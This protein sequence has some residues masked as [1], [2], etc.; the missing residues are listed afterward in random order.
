MSNALSHG[1]LRISVAGATGRIGSALLSRLVSDDVE[2]VALSRDPSTD[3]LPRGIAPTV[4][5]F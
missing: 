5:D 1:A 2:I 4:I 3:R